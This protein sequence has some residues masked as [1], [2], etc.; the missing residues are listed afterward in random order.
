M[1][2]SKQV[3]EAAGVTGVLR[4]S[5]CMLAVVCKIAFQPPLNKLHKEKH[6]HS[7]CHI[8]KK[9]VTSSQVSYDIFTTQKSFYEIG[10][11]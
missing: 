11:W 10:F 9:L 6:L 1:F 7:P 4:S 8:H 5:P 2:S 3:F